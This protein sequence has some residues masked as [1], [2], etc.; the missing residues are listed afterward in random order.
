MRYVS[1]TR[2]GRVVPRSPGRSVRV[3]HSMHTQ[4]YAVSQNRCSSGSRNPSFPLS[5]PPLH[6]T[7][8][9]KRWPSTGLQCSW[10]QCKAH[11]S[12]KYRNQQGAVSRRLYSFGRLL[13]RGNRCCDLTCPAFCRKKKMSA[14]YH[15]FRASYKKLSEKKEEGTKRRRQQVS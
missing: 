14:K 6:S 11:V 5:R 13:W 12:I 8:H 15:A 4:T 3:K 1:C 9:S 10:H 7:D 2:R